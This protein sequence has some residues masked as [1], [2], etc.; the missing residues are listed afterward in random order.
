MGED[1]GGPL[2][3]EKGVEAVAARV[4]RGEL[5]ADAGGERL[6]AADLVPQREELR[7][8]VRPRPPELRVGVGLRGVDEGTV[9]EHDE[10]RVERV[11]AVLRDAAAH[12]GRV[13]GE[14]AADHG[15]VDRS[16]VGPDAGAVGGE[17]AVEVR[18]DHSRLR[19]D[20]PP[21]VEHARAA[22]V[23]ADL[24]EHV[25]AHRLARERGARGPEGHV[26]AAAGGPGEKLA[27]LAEAAR[28]DDG[29]G[30]QAVDRGVSGAAQ[31]VD[32]PRE[33]AV[34]REDPLEVPDDSGVGG[35]HGV[36]CQGAAATGTW[37]RYRVPPA[38][39]VT[40]VVFRVVS[41]SRVMP[42]ASV[43]RTRPPE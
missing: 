35:S 29:L 19:P 10:E 16:R 42:W 11:V 9:G 13:V 8:E 28:P 6:V 32:R 33:D 18:A 23:R 41:W 26:A 21:V 25:V 14:D 31:P 5:V 36:S 43:R 17:E 4:L 38:F 2:E 20:P 7:V 1:V 12:P 22:E 39:R 15:R 3:V 30:N 27:D 34:R 37:N 24:D 40:T